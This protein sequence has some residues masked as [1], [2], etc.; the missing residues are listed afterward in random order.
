MLHGA[1]FQVEQK[2]Q[3]TTRN[4]TGPSLRLNSDPSAKIVRIYHKCEGG[5]KKILSRGS[6]LGQ[7]FR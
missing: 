6:T 3:S 1:M 5:I 7:C 4:K 2:I